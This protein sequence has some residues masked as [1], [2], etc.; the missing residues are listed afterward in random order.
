VCYYFNKDIWGV[1]WAPAVH[2]CNP[3]F[4]GGRDQEDPDSKPM[5]GK[6]FIRPH[7]EKP[8]H[9]KGLVD[10]GVAQGVGSEFKLQY[11]KKIKEGI[12]WGGR[13]NA[14][15]SQTLTP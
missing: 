7:L 13:R 4:S 1:R 3:S 9:K 10:Y 5:Q 12:W 2:T 6:E 14:L 11:C 8:H 15:W